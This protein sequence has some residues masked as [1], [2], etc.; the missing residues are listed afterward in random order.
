MQMADICVCMAYADVLH[1][2]MPHLPSVLS[3]SAEIRKKAKSDLGWLI[4]WKGER[5]TTG[6]SSGQ[7]AG[8]N[9]MS[10]LSEKR[11]LLTSRL[12]NQKSAGHIPLR[13][14]IQKNS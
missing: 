6:R 5:D 13:Q 1:M 3:F 9:G 8:G 11:T 2:D 12:V 4:V 7:N 14:Y 10:A